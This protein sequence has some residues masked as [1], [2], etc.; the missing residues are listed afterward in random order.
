MKMLK[1]VFSQLDPS[2][3]HH[4]GIDNGSV[5]LSL[6]FVT[7]KS[8]LLVRIECCKDLRSRDLRS[9]ACNPYVKVCR[10]STKKREI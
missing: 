4:G 2:V 10:N 3:I 1:N 7:S 8:L 6:K 9:R 5:E